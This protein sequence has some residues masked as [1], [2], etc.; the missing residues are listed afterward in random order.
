MGS[1]RWGQRS[2]SKGLV[3]LTGER[4]SGENEKGAKITTLSFHSLHRGEQNQKQPERRMKKKRR[5]NRLRWKIEKG[6][7]GKSPRYPMSAEL[8]G[9]SGSQDRSGAN[10]VEVR[11]R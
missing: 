2:V 5:K 8:G 6:E 1:G 3:G 4:R 7:N 11:A 9:K 10:K